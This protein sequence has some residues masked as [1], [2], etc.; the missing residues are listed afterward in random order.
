MLAVVLW[1]CRAEQPGPAF[2]VGMSKRQ[3][4]EE[5]GDPEQSIRMIK[6][7]EAAW[8]AI[9]NYWSQMETGEEVTIWYYP[10]DSGTI[11]LYFRNDDTTLADFG[12]RPEGAVY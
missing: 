5:Y 4:V 6:R 12:F 8:G 1:G 3:I 10:S 9:E 7:T 2:Q 11:E